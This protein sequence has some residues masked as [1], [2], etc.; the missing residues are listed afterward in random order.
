[1]PA[2]GGPSPEGFDAWN[3]PD[4]CEDDAEDTDSELAATCAI[5]HF[6]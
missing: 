3:V 2:A 1:M 4:A 6:D 5:D